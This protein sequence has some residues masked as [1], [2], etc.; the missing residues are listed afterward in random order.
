[1]CDCIKKVNEALKEADTNT[2]LDVPMT[3]NLGTHKTRADRLTVPTV[4]A[5]SRNK[6]KKQ[7]IF[8]TYCPF[9]GEKYKAA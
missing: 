4:K 5:N 3:I 2:V 7:T 6:K 1:M 8:A 9:C